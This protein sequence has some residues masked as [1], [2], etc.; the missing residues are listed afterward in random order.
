VKKI[1][2]LHGFLSQPQDMEPLFISGFECHSLNIKSFQD[3]PEDVFKSYN[4]SFD[5]SVAY[6]FGGRFL[7][8]LLNLRP[9]FINQPIFCSARL[10]AYTPEELIQREAFRK[11]LLEKLEQ[12]VDVFYDYWRSIPLFNGHSMEQ[13][14]KEHSIV[15]KKW[16]FEEIQSFLLNHFTYETPNLEL[17]KSRSYFLFGGLDDKYKAEAKRLNMKSYEFENSG[18]RFLFENP[19]NFKKYLKDEILK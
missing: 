7:A 9:D 12:S 3:R 10:T 17:F 4:Q 2:Y 19:L 18:H 11:I 13:F 14:R 16:S 6:S 8:H 15:Y 1:L 5:Y